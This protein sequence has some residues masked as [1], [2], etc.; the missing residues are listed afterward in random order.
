MT[1]H[2]K[3]PDDA[4]TGQLLLQ[5]HDYAV[6]AQ[7]KVGTQQGS[8]AEGTNVWSFTTKSDGEALHF[9]TEDVKRTSSAARG[10]RWRGA[11]SPPDS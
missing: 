2:L 9:T 4:Y 7:P 5:G 8:F 11:T 3:V 1:L 10:R 6:Q